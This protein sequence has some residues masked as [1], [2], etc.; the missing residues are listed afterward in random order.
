M[1]FIELGYMGGRAE[2]AMKKRAERTLS[3][4]EKW[5]P[6]FNVPLSWIMALAEMESSH[7]PTKVNMTARHKGGAWGLLQQ[8]ADEVPYKLKVIRRFYGRRGDKY[9][10]RVRRTLRK[11][12]GNPKALLDPNLNVMLAAWQLGRLNRVFGGDF[13][14]AF[15]AYHQGEFAVKRRLRKG[16]P[17]V[18]SSKQPKGYAYVKEAAHARM[19]YVPMLIARLEERLAQ[20]WQPYYAYAD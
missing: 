19:R 3:Y 5:A 2:A 14:K 15:A 6:V 13:A 17:A 10:K 11:W 8:M 12:K 9:A 16:H 4:A 18:D 20:Q 1:S 7:I